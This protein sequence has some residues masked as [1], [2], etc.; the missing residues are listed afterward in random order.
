MQIT[1]E[2][3]KRKF[4][5]EYF[6]DSLRYT[7]EVEFLQLTQGSKPVVEYAERFKDLG[8]FYT[9]PFDEEW[10]CRKFEN[11]LKGD[12][13]LMVAPLSIKNFAALVEKAK[14]MERMKV[15]VKAQ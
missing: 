14:V 4:L 3:F 15:E 1:W 2:A 10:H 6:S 11:G 9:M 13:C 12:I 5:S 8:H 7:K